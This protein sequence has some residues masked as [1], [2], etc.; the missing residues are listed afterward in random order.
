MRIRSPLFASLVALVSTVSGAD[1]ALRFYHE[2][3]I[4]ALIAEPPESFA[5]AREQVDAVQF[6]V[7]LH[8]DLSN[9]VRDAFRTNA[10]TEEFIIVNE[11]VETVTEATFDGLVRMIAAAEATGWT[12]GD[13]LVYREPLFDELIPSQELHP[14][15]WTDRRLVSKRDVACLRRRLARARRAGEIR[16]ERYSIC[17]L[18]YSGRN[19]DKEERRFI[20]KS[21]DGLYVELNTRGGAWQV[22]GNRST[23]GE[24]FANPG[25]DF[26]AFGLPGTDDTAA[27]LDWCLDRKLR[28]GITAGANLTDRWFPAL[29][30][31]LCGRLRTRGVDPDAPEIT[32]LL[33]HNRKV[34]D[35]GLLF[36]PETEPHSMTWLAGFIHRE[37]RSESR[38]TEKPS[39]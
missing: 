35:G 38:G 15:P 37:I 18:V 26:V 10:I 4:R 5:T 23:I 30:R 20:E 22:E 11:P 27:L 33:H 34:D 32:W 39:E 13:I 25:H 9:P 8:P 2:H 28:T 1:V 21:L 17:G 19:L 14:G 31:D 24:P 12:W 3:E 7:H 16:E 6:P 29:F 36:F